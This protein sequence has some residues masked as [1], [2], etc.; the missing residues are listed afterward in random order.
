MRSPAWWVNRIFKKTLDYTDK[1]TKDAESRANSK[2]DALDASKEEKI[3][4]I[5]VPEILGDAYKPWMTE[6]NK[7]FYEEVMAGRCHICKIAANTTGAGAAYMTGTPMWLINTVFVSALYHFGTS[8]DL[9]DVTFQ[10]ITIDSDGDARLSSISYELLHKASLKTINQQSLIGSGN[11][12]IEGGGTD[13]DLYPSEYSD[14]FNDD[15]T[16]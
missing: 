16:N 4:T 11:I 12:E 14:E 9:P 2:I 13:V 7:R 10:L 6:E 1:V 15:F 8:D 3:M 5:Y